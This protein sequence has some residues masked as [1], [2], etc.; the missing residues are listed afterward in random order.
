MDREALMS[1]I[2]QSI[3]AMAVC[4]ASLVSTIDDALAL[5]LG[6]FGD[7]SYT[8]SDIPE[9]EANFR[10]GSLD[11]YAVQYIDDKTRALFEL[12]FQ[13]FTGEFE[14]EIQRYWIMR[15]FS[16][17]FHLGMGRFH[18][19][20]GYWS[21]HFHHGILMQD[22]VSR[23][24]MLSFEGSV[25]AI[26]PMHMVGLLSEGEIG[27]SGFHYEAGIANSNTIDTVNGE[28]LEVPNRDD[29]SAD[30]SF[31]GRLSFARPDV[32]YMPGVFVMH[33]TLVESDAVGSF[34]GVVRGDDLVEQ[35]M[36]GA[37]LRYEGK[38]FALLAELYHIENDAQAGVGDGE[39]HDALAYFAQFG[40]HLTE[41]L[42]ATYRYE[43][44]DFDSDDPYFMDPNLLGRDTIG[45]ETRDVFCLR[46]DFS[47][48]NALMLEVTL[49]D[50][51][52]ADSTATTI[53]SWAFVMF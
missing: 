31:F 44:L 45:T 18:P 30:K 3:G 16:D 37:D 34:P 2:G 48:S 12:Q 35:A 15:E 19:P 38:R 52:L 33:N 29:L 26:M 32:P 43:S 5:D 36:I 20:I 25:N 11:F 9:D 22:T 6:V 21:R 47:E 42:L 7:L 40:Y 17:A 50:P 49:R 14:Y 23:P 24:F 53:L 28:G 13:T 51:E 10:I 46:Y 4:A 8:A 27:G 41:Q 1:K 39:T